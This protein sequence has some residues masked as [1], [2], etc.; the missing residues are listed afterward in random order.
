M[1]AS[2][3]DDPHRVL[4][5]GE[6]DDDVRLAVEPVS[7]CLISVLAVVFSRISPNDGACAIERCHVGERQAALADI[8][9]VLPRVLVVLHGSI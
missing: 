1:R 7:Q 2:K 4:S 3:A 5:H 6:D 9:G 8:P